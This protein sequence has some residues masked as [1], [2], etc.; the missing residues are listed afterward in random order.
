MSDQHDP[1][2]ASIITKGSREYVLLMA[3]RQGLRLLIA[4][5]EKYLEIENA[6]PP[7]SK[8]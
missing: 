4:A 7:R 8:R 6:F 3:F 1:Q 5:I 2:N